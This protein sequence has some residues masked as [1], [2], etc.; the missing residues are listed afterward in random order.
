MAPALTFHPN[1]KDL[2]CKGSYTEGF[3]TCS[4][5]VQAWKVD[6]SSSTGQQEYILEFNRRSQR[7]REAFLA[8]KRLVAN[9]LKRDGFATHWAHGGEIYPLPVV[10]NDLGELSMPGFHESSRSPYPIT[11]REEDVADMT[12]CINEHKYPQS[13]ESLELLA[14]CGAGSDKNREVL[15][16][17]CELAKAI[18]QELRTGYEA[19]SCLHALSLIDQGAT[20]PKDV[21]PAVARCL[22][23]HSG[24]KRFNRKGARSRAIESTALRVMEKLVCLEGSQLVALSKIEEE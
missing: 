1:S 14:Q 9:A 8:L 20:A 10:E 5:V 16:E 22:Q 3:S 23:V 19:N 17:N 13:A 21:L 11:L 18:H 7:G 15:R 4:F 6:N 12:A 2:R 24:F